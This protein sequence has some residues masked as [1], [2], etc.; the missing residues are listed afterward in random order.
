MKGNAK[1]I[2]ALNEA[3]QEELLAIN[4]YFYTQRCARTGSM[5][6]SPNSSRNS[7]LTR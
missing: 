7:R 2:A 6:R 1:V 3:L 4:Q 5:R